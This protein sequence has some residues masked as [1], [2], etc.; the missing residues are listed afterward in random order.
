MPR[1]DADEDSTGGEE[2]EGTEWA[3]ARCAGNGAPPHAGGRIARRAFLGRLS[4]GAAAAGLGPLASTTAARAA[5]PLDGRAAAS[6]QVG[7]GNNTDAH[8]AA[9]RAIA[10]C[11]Q[12]PWSGTALAGKTV[13][14]KPNLVIAAASTTGATTDPQV[15]RAIVDL[16]LEAGASQVKIVEVGHPGKAV[17]YDTCGYT[18]VFTTTAYPQVQLVDLGM[19]PNNTFSWVTVPHPMAFQKL[20]VPS[21]LL[22]P[23]I[24]LISAAK[25]KT[26]AQAGVT[27]TMKNL[28]GFASP[29]LYA[30]SGQLPRMD[31]HYRGVY[32]AVV[33][34]NMA[35][36][37]QF[38]VVDGI[39]GMEGNGPTRGTPIRVN[40]VVAGL[41]P[42]AVD[43]I[44]LRQVMG[45]LQYCAP[46]LQYAAAR[47]LGPASTSEIAVLGDAFTPFSFVPAQI[48]PL[49]WDTVASPFSFS[50]SATP[51][52]TIT[53]MV[54]SA[55]S[56]RVEIIHDSDDTPGITV[57]R[58]LHDWAARPQGSESVAWDGRDDS[59]RLVAPGIYLARV[60]ARFSPDTWPPTNY[61]TSI[62]MVYP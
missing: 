8:T 56:T 48:P 45:Q 61:A 15:V 14:I 47:G 11:G 28:Y 2:H 44:C 21:M 62:V 7:V 1:W 35:L 5:G 18:T 54:G 37:I 10:A 16:V 27:L 29:T 58:T 59:G 41:N 19:P 52:T 32:E 34:L 51:L 60:Q 4:A 23:N 26:H 49:L 30:V 50:L 17:P 55:C 25:M 38:G 24:V 3:D 36:P 12:W 53:Y 42:L 57:V 6:Y 22:D 39:W 43:W 9:R 31:L 46:Y 40:L 20:S 13:V 33:D